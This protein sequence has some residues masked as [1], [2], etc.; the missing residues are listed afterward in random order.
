MTLADFLRKIKRD[1]NKTFRQ[2]GEEIG[3][4]YSILSRIVRGRVKRPDDATLWSIALG[5]GLHINDVRAMADLPPL[6]FTPWDSLTQAQRE[7]VDVLRQR[8]QLAE[9]FDLLRREVA[10]IEGDLLAF[11]EARRKR[12]NP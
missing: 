2:M 12:R 8:P 5:Y 1:G 11:V 10:G 6:D 9:L 4:D 7:A 3:V